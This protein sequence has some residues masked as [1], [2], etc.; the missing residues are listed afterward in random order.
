MNAPD[1]FSPAFIA[2]PYPLYRTMRDDHPL[3]FHAAAN[4]HVL[5]RYNDVRLATTSAEFTTQSYATQLE[6]LLGLTIIQLD[7]V[8]H[9]RQ[10]RLLAAPFRT[11]NIRASF[12]AAI[13]AHA[14]RLIAGFRER[15]E[16]E[17]VAEFIAAYPVGV[18]AA[19]LGLP[20]QD[21][22]QFRTWYTALL[23]FGLNLVGDPEVTRAGLSA[24]DALDAYL[25][26]VVAA[27]R[28]RPGASLLAMLA[29]S[30]VDGQQLSD[31]E[32]VR[33]GMLMIFAGGE[34][35]EKTLATFMR[36]LVAHPEQLAELRER[37]ELMSRALAES[38]RYTAPTHMIP[39]RTC[40]AVQVSG[41]E[42][43]ADT[44]VLC[45][46]GSANRDERRFAQPDRFDMHRADLDSDRAF[47][48]AADHLAFGA[49]RHFCIGA[50]L[51]KFEV[52]V[53]MGCL[54][55]AMY[56][57]RFADNAPP[58]DFGLFLRGPTSLKLRYRPMHR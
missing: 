35:V 37:P 30:E 15:G 28:G 17:L 5:S 51:A 6:P 25:R 56:D 38:M 48:A 3:Y 44:E 12:G 20:P 9:A 32:I 40:S 23:R 36:N 58:P 34:T 1:I 43:P 50:M 8:D 18:L 22:D 4:A 11:D 57:I 49:G 21:R 45:F 27:H 7:G 26:P 47:S 19:I 42:I 29:N 14:E 53:A 52:E 55:R 33:F 39:R 24:R 41:G 54:L 2:D 10:R 13:A 31:D 46:L 16:V